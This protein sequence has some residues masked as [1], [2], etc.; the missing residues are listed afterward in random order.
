MSNKSWMIG[1]ILIGAGGILSLLYLLFGLFWSVPKLV[2]W[3]IGLLFLIYIVFNYFSIKQHTIKSWG[4]SLLIM[5]SSAAIVYFL[6][7]VLVV[8]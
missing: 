5:L 1:N 4:A 8:K 7:V 6:H 2:P 3:Y